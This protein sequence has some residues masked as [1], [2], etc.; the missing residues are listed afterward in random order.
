MVVVE[1]LVMKV[2]FE[3][4]E[5]VCP[6]SQLPAKAVLELKSVNFQLWSGMGSWI[7]LA[8]TSAAANRIIILLICAITAESGENA[9]ART[10]EEAFEERVEEVASGQ[11]AKLDF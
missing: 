9:Q 10:P 6:P 7:Y 11:Q 5:E 2:V 4:V 3:E 8:K 1:D